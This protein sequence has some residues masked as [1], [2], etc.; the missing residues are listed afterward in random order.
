MKDIWDLIGE[1]DLRAAARQEQR[2]HDEALDEIRRLRAETE[3]LRA[4]VAESER[5]QRRLDWLESKKD[6]SWSYWLIEVDT[7]GICIQESSGGSEGF[8]SDELRLAIDAAMD[9]EASDGE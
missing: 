9:S 8:E 3:R 2:M 7:D 5:D 6:P 1:G 4:R